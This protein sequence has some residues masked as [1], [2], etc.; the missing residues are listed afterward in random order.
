MTQELPL[1]PPSSV[2]APD[3]PQPTSASTMTLVSVTPTPADTSGDDTSSSRT[4]DI[5]IPPP[6][7]FEGKNNPFVSVSELLGNSL[8]AGTPITLPLPLAPVITQPVLRPTK[9][10]LSEKDIRINRNGEVK[11]RRIRRQCTVSK[12]AEIVVPSASWNSAKSLRSMYNP[13]SSNNSLEFTLNGRR[14]RKP[15][16][17]SNINITPTSSPIKQ[18]PTISLDDLKTSVN[19]YFGAANRIASGEKFK[20]RAKRITP[21]G[22]T[23]YLIEWESTTT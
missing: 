16:Q 1:T 21:Q 8:P 23:Q 6:K 22:R 7:D 3:T 18:T 10:R 13:T 5:F 15:K 11:R 12:N 17:K 20:I 4:L 14:L 2:S 19:I 9:R